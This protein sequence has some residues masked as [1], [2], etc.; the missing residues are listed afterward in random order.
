ST[1]TKKTEMKEKKKKGSWEARSSQTIDK[2]LSKEL[3]I[4]QAAVHCYIPKS[5]VQNKIK[6]L[7][8]REE[9]KMKRKFGRFT[10]TFLAEYERVLVY[11][12]T[13]LSNRCMPLTRKVTI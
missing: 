6:A 10:W 7:N 1:T 4:R 5:T 13:H 8:R 3:S 11:H 9:V 12:G 2:V